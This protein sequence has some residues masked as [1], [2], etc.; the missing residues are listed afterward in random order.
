MKIHKIDILYL[1]VILLAGIYFSFFRLSQFYSYNYDQERDYL[2]VKQIVDQQR[3]ALIGPRVVSANGFFLGPWYYYTLLPFYLIFHGDPLFGAYMAG[4]FNI[5]TAFAFFFL[6]RRKSSFIALCFSLMWLTPLSNRMSWNVTFV[7]LFVLGFTSLFLT[8]KPKIG[9]ALIATFLASLG[10]NF[11]FQIVFFVPVVMAWIIYNR[12]SIRL[13]IPNIVSLATVFLL[14]FSPLLFFDLRHNFVN[15]SGAIRFLQQKS[16]SNTSQIDK[17]IFSFRNLTRELSFI[18]PPFNKYS[19]Y[20]YLTVPIL[21]VAF[22]VRSVFDKPLR[23]LILVVYISIISLFLYSQS[24]WPEYYQL[25]AAILLLILLA[26]FLS[27]FKLG[28]ALAL[29]LTI[30]LI[31]PA[32]TNL[33]KLTDGQSYFY[34]RNTMNYIL[35]NSKPNRPNIINEFPLGEGYGF[36][37]IRDYYEDKALTYS[38]S[39]QYFLSYSSNKKHN[40]TLKTFGVFGVSSIK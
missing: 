17:F 39:N 14:P 2:A 8:Q 26:Y 6:L 30:F 16:L 33:Y 34:K 19:V 36:G 3:P 32:G 31:I 4:F 7:P 25:T 11:H 29:L 15:F 21:L 20:K 1:L 5:V 37:T 12:Q 18:L 22:T 10:I 13:S 24:F 23:W 9:H 27:A 38:P 35:E 40:S 28:K